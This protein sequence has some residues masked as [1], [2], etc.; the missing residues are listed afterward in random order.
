MKICQLKKPI[1]VADFLRENFTN[2][3]R[4]RFLRSGRLQ[5]SEGRK[6]ELLSNRFQEHLM[7]IQ[8]FFQ[9]NEEQVQNENTN[10]S[11]KEMMNFKISDFLV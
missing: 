7:Y 4:R 2:V 5:I 1:A 9:T 3:K 6:K 8:F 10:L 11:Q